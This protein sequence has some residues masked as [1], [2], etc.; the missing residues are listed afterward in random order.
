M[1][2]SSQEGVMNRKSW[3]TK[4]ITLC[5]QK[6]GSVDERIVDTAYLDLSKAFNSLFCS[7]LIGELL[8]TE[9]INGQLA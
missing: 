8:T 5:D 1:V 2:V 3:L 6:A 9:W 4:P 7:I